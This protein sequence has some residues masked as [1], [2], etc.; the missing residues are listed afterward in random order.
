MVIAARKFLNNLGSTKLDDPNV[1]AEIREHAVVL[2]AHVTGRELETVKVLLTKLDSLPSLQQNAQ[3]LSAVV[4]QQTVRR[5]ALEAKDAEFREQLQKRQ[6]NVTVCDRKLAE[7]EA[8]KAE[9]EKKIDKCRI[10]KA[11]QSEYLAEEISVAENLR[12]TLA[13]TRDSVK[14][15]TFEAEDKIVEY[16]RTIVDITSLGRRV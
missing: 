9:L 5:S 13:K 11:K 8:F 12:Q 15:A 1:V 2:E 3:Q 7:L 14:Q 10:N 6:A 16:Q 4:Q